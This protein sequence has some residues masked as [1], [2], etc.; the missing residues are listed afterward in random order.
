MCFFKKR[1]LYLEL[2]YLDDARIP[3]KDWIL[4]T[5]HERIVPLE[6]YSVKTK[7]ATGE[8]LLRNPRG[9]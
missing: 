3:N 6:G 2:K 4:D 5:I 9:I 7:Q 1:F 8:I